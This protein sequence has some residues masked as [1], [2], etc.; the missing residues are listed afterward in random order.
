MTEND[1]VEKLID[2]TARLIA[3]AHLRT[4]KGVRTH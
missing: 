3:R 1:P 2:L 4:Q